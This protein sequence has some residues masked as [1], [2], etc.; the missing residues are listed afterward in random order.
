[1]GLKRETVSA[2][3]R[4]RWTSRVTTFE[5]SVVLFATAAVLLLGSWPYLEAFRHEPAGAEFT[6]LLSGHQD[7]NTY[8]VKIDAGRRGQ[9]LYRNPYQALPPTPLPLHFFWIALGWLARA[10]GVSAIT[11]FH[12][13]R[14]GAGGLF[15]IC[16][17]RLLRVCLRETRP[18]L[19]G[20]LLLTVSSGASGLVVHLSFFRG[21]RFPWFADVMVPESNTF[22]S[23]LMNPAFLFC[24]A[25]ISIASASLIRAVD[26]RGGAWG[27][28]AATL[29]LGLVHPMSM[30]ALWIVLGAF[31]L[32]ESVVGSLGR[33]RASTLALRLVGTSVPA[34]A[35]Y[36][37]LWRLSPEVRVW[38]A[39]NLCPSP[40]PLSYLGGYGVLWVPAL[41]GA[42]ACFRARRPAARFAL[43]WLLLGF[44]LLYSPV[45]VQRRLS[46]GYHLAVVLAVS[47]AL[48]RPRWAWLWP[49]LMVLSVPTTHLLVRSFT[50]RAGSGTYPSFV[51]ESVVAGMRWLRE[52]RPGA[53]V[54]CAPQS[55][56][57]VTRYGNGRVVAGHW[58]ETPDY[59][60]RADEVRDLLVGVM[61][62]PEAVAWLDRWGVEALLWTPRET[63]LAGHGGPVAGDW[64]IVWQR[65]DVTI[66]ER[67]QGPRRTSNAELPSLRQQ[68]LQHLA[69]GWTRTRHRARGSGGTGAPESGSPEPQTLKSPIPQHS[70][71]PQFRHSAAARQGGAG[72]RCA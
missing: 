66:W 71:S 70:T 58:A 68:R 22:F 44:A 26:G 35:Y 62:P 31:L 24:M 54:L 63:A 41:A 69:A 19:L 30:A 5:A 43:L 9:I 4:A 18:S 29:V 7:Y 16:A 28:G 49:V 17:Y 3:R 56:W 11:A 53:V 67:R 37:A 51:E 1:L 8:L 20:F 13:A 48:A 46:E 34:A 72:T 55:A 33:R 64:S 36:F 50:E 23:L 57:L 15:L 61:T 2:E 59:S 12:A 65:G 14:V 21:D 52:T 10:A 40:H 38:V 25:M 47:M 60:A 45:S 6:G 32:V 42:L 39:Q 27:A